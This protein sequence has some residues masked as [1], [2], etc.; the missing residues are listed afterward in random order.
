VAD[1]YR[2]LAAP[3][4]AGAAL[5]SFEFRRAREAT[6]TELEDLI[7]RVDRRGLRGLSAEELTR[8]PLLYRATLSSLSVARSISLDKNLL[9]YLESLAA[10]AYF[11]VYGTR[12]HL[13]ETVRDFVLW[14]F[15]AA[16]RRH[17]WHLG[18]AALFIVL[19]AVAG[20]V[21]TA[22]NPDRFYTFVD[23]EYAG[24][25]GP[26]AS[27]AELRAVLYDRGDVGDALATFASFLFTHNARIGMMAFALGFL[28]GLPVFILCFTNGLVLGAFGALYTSRGLGVDF[29]GWVLPHG[30]TELLAVALCGGA[31]LVLAQSLV[32]PGRM[33]RLRNMAA[34][35]RRA[36]VIVI[37][38]VCL[39]FIAGLIEG[40]FRQTVHS[41]PVRYAV[42]GGTAA[43]WIYYFGWVGRRRERLERARDQEIS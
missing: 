2:N 22:G 13:R 18:L 20:Y 37:G 21:I 25:R 29:W 34:G 7:D 40:I 12:R 32:F 19:G 36:A 38:A 26:A 42:A 9:D 3:A 11:A 6:W 16:V 27:T 5:K 14:R 17:R 10:R 15:P 23:P 30:V 28:A 24:G 35:G 33:T 41:V 4:P 39:F 1:P 31:G 8:L 43:F